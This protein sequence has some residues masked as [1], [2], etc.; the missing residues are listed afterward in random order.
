MT[1]FIMIY[2][3]INGIFNSV[4]KCTISTYTGINETI[5]LDQIIKSKDRRHSF[6][7]DSSEL[8]TTHE[9]WFS[10]HLTAWSATPTLHSHVHIRR[11]SPHTPHHR[12]LW[13]QVPFTR[14]WCGL[15]CDANPTPSFYGRGT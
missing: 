9:G 7:I 14:L 6:E 3:L 5:I 12:A 11:C 1:C 10:H 8:R 13:Q 4:H 15:A 2:K